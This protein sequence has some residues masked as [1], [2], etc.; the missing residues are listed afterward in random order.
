MP[1]LVKKPVTR[2]DVLT[3]VKNLRYAAE[4]LEGC[5]DVALLEDIEGL[6]DAARADV[7]ALRH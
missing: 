1:D 2:D 5:D 4:L 7:H 6:I 3:A